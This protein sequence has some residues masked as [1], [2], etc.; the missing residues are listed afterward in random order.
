MCGG[1]VVEHASIIEQSLAFKGV[2]AAS[3]APFPRRGTPRD[4]TLYFEHM[5]DAAFKVHRL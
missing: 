4:A 2:S 5:Q 3:I 1:E